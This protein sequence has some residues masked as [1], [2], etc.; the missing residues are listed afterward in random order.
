MHTGGLK[1]EA[2][3]VSL[4]AGSIEARTLE[5]ICDMIVVGTLEHLRASELYEALEQ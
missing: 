1:A 3:I 2:D 4:A 5:I